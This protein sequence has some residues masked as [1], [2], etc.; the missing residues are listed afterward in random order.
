M[1]YLIIVFYSLIVIEKGNAYTDN[2]I[3][4][5]FAFRRRRKKKSAL[6]AIWANANFSSLPTVALRRGNWKL[7]SKNLGITFIFCLPKRGRNARAR[8]KTRQIVFGGVCWTKSELI[9]RKIRKRIFESRPSVSARFRFAT[10]SKTEKFSLHFFNRPLA[11]FFSIKE[12]KIFLFWYSANAELR[13][14]FPAPLSAFGGLASGQKFL[15]PNPLPFC[16]LA[17]GLRPIFFR[18]RGYCNL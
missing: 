6:F 3:K 14:R 10:A 8:W 5:R 1:K 17:F 4:F 12:T 7:I 16:P 9:L 11:K 13:K 15:P 18:R 2:L